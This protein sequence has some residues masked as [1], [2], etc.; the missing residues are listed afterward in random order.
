MENQ[1]GTS[2]D[3][4]FFGRFYSLVQR[5]LPFIQL[6]FAI[7]SGLFVLSLL[8]WLVIESGS[9]GHVIIVFNLG[10]LSLLLVSTGAILYFVNPP[11]EKPESG[12]LS[13]PPRG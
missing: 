8:V 9:D 2:S 3:T 12:A 7:E 1:G 5:W 6:A 13:R 4:G 10:L 11:N